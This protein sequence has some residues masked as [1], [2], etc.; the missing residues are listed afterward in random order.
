MRVK[1]FLLV[2]CYFLADINSVSSR[3]AV[4]IPPIPEVYQPPLPEDAELDEKKLQWLED[5]EQDPEVTPGLFQGDMAMDNEVFS[6][7]RVGLRW[8]VF[9]DRLWK[10]RTVPYI[11]SPLYEPDEYITIYKAITTI[12]YMTCVK[13]VPWNG[14][15]KDFLIIWPIKYPK[16]CW[17]F[18]G[19]FGGAQIVSLQPP[20]AKG[21]NCLGNEGRAM[22]ELLHAIGI[23]HEQSRADRDKFVKINLSNVLPEFRSNFDKQSLDNTSYTFE[24]DYDSIMHYGKYF[25][26]TNKSKPVITPKFP[27][28]KLGQRKMLSKT[29]C[30]KVNQLYGCL[31]K[32]KYSQKKYYNLCNFLGL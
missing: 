25:F 9:P 20:D 8:D 29:D 5:S 21:P 30:L 10:N 1:Y 26:S 2:L 6:Y 12:N 4:T 15:A 28:T 24:Y 27:A 22:H 11:I 13:F 7:W 32:S 31:E 18:V 16:G 3:S 17:S 19:R 14:K 23:F